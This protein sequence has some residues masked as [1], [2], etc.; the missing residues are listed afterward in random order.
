MIDNKLSL[1]FVLPGSTLLSSQ[2]CEENPKENYDTFKITLKETKGKNKKSS[3]ESIYVKTRKPKT[4]SQHLNMTTEAYL[5][6]LNTPVN[7]KLAKVVKM[8]KRGN[9]VRAWDML[10][11]HKKLSHHI[12]LIAHDL[13][14]ISYKFEILGD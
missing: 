3:T 9:P 1:T 4:I 14:A 8:D 10:S 6:M 11:E 7:T 13:H 12:D 2:E 5:H